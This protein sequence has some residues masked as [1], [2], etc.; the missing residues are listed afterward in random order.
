M[1]AVQ[2]S[3]DH[4]IGE[5]QRKLTAKIFLGYSIWIFKWIAF[6]F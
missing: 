3:D 4:S 2:E 6:W 1:Q 5:I